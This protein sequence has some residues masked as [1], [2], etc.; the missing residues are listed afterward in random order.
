MGNVSMN[1]ST[2]MLPIRAPSIPPVSCDTMLPSR[3]G[4]DW[5]EPPLLLPAPLDECR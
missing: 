1:T 2:I 5:D 4:E 3:V